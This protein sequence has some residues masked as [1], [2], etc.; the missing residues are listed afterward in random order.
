MHKCAQV[1]EWCGRSSTRAHGLGKS[2]N[3]CFRKVRGVFGAA[4]VAR[5]EHLHCWGKT[6]NRFFHTSHR[7]CAS[8]V[9]VCVNGEK[10][11]KKKM[12]DMINNTN[13]H[14]HQNPPQSQPYDAAGLLPWV[15]LVFLQAGFSE[16]RIAMRGKTNLKKNLKNFFFL[17]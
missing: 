9:C 8:V 10:N 17:H 13:L 14:R 2:R 7:L 16:F 1:C 3:V 4:H 12:K 15:Q 5:V 11:T 6:T